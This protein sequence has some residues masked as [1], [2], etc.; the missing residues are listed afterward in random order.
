M[1][2]T[3]KM[4]V[5]ASASAVLLSGTHISAQ[6]FT[7]DPAAAQSSSA[8][9]GSGNGFPPESSIGESDAR[10]VSNLYK[11]AKR[12][13]DNGDYVLATVNLEKALKIAPNNAHLT[14]TLG[15]TYYTLGNNDRAIQLLEK[16]LV[17][18]VDSIPDDLR[19]IAEQMLTDIQS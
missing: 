8:I 12:Q 7:P 17:S 14:Y 4:F 1:I 9:L 2:L 13:L 11:K 19:I 3:T 16:T 18:D 10:L 5:L 15:G 6:S